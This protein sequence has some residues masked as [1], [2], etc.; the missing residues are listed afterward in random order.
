MSGLEERPRT[1]IWPASAWKTVWV[2]VV[3]TRRVVGRPT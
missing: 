2:M 1:L 3:V